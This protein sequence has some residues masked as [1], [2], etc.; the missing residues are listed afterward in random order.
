MLESP[1]PLLHGKPGNH[2]PTDRAGAQGSTVPPVLLDLPRL[3]ELP[4]T[5]DGCCCSAAVVLL[6]Q[7]AVLRARS[8][9]LCYKIS[10]LQRLL[11]HHCS[12]CWFQ[13]QKGKKFPLI[14]CQCYPS[15]QSNLG[16]V[17]FRFSHIREHGRGGN[18]V[19][20]QQTNDLHRVQNIFTDRMYIFKNWRI[21]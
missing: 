7:P 18:G 9:D 15:Q 17:V 21:Y 11:K 3:V 10:V 19:E 5:C 16:N 2:T 13:K 4:V 6:L 12:D 8:Q 14:I 20:N 1:W